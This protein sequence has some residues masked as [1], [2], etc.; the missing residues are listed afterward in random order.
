MPAFIFWFCA[1]LRSRSSKPAGRPSRSPIIS[2]RSGEVLRSEI[3]R[4]LGHHTADA[5][6][7]RRELLRAGHCVGARLA[8]G[9]SAERLRHWRDRAEQRL[10]I[11][12]RDI[13]CMLLRIQ[14]RIGAIV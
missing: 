14:D 6:C 11:L 7:D 1:E 9:V 2:L 10:I 5:A 3:H 4:T 12:R 8:P 13:E